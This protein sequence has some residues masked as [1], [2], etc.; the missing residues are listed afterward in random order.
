MSVVQKNYFNPAA[1]GQRGGTYV[2]VGE[3][4]SARAWSKITIRIRTEKLANEYANGITSTPSGWHIFKCSRVAQF[5]VTDDIGIG[6]TPGKNGNG[7]AEEVRPKEVL[8][9]RETQDSRT[10]RPKRNSRHCE[11][12][13]GRGRKARNHSLKVARFEVTGGGRFQ[14]TPGWF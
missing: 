2:R 1:Q 13:S 4:G 14:S 12:G 7:D 5:E 10:K 9:S 6:E 3:A 11:I 8:Q